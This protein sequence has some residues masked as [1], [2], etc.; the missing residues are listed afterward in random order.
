MRCDDLTAAQ[1]RALKNQLQPLLSYLNRLKHRM[2]RRGFPSNDRLLTAVCR[3]EEAV[4]AL[5]VE[6]HYLGC[7]DKVFRPSGQTGGHAGPRRK[8]QPGRD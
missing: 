3:A 5:H 6:I 2:R 7:G 4:H 1:A 8:K